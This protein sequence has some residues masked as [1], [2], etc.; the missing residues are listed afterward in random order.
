MKKL[1]L[2]LLVIVGMSN[3]LSAQGVAAGTGQSVSIIIPD[4]S[5]LSTTETSLSFDFTIQNNAMTAGDA[6]NAT[7]ITAVD[8]LKVSNIN[9]GASSVTKIQVTAS[10]IPSGLGLS[11]KVTAPTGPGKAGT[12][13]AVDATY[14]MS[15]TPL[16]G[17]TATDIVT[18]I[19]TMNTG[20]AATE[21]YKVEY[22]LNVTDLTAL[23]SI[24][25]NVST[26]EIMYTISS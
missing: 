20:V 25:Q 22:E 15:L 4:Y 2:S 18:Q 13:G 8:Y 17:G 16:P 10:N 3:S 11:L 1:L 9:A 24:L 7:A 21:G 12:L 26:T 14:V 6:F 5:H 19:G 23:T